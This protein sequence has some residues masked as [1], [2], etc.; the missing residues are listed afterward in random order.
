MQHSGRGTFHVWAHPHSPWQLQSATL[1]NGES[2]EFT[3][4]VAFAQNCQFSGQYRADSFK[5]PEALQ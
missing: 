3:Q 2:S 5:T 1:G 4:K